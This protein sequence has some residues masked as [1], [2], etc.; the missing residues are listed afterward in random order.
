MKK[1][2]TVSTA[3]IDLVENIR[4]EC[5]NP[6]TLL[7]RVNLLISGESIEASYIVDEKCDGCEHYR[8]GRT[9]G[10]ITHDTYSTCNIILKAYN[11]LKT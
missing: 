3:I 1:S 6:D 9:R 2:K 5:K 7:S 4:K 8:L 11:S 10:R